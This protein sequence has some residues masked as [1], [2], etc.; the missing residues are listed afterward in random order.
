MW[1][2][3]RD[4]L[5][6]QHNFIIDSR[7][8]CAEVYDRDRNGLRDDELHPADAARRRVDHR[9]RAR[10]LD[11]RAVLLAGA[12]PQLADVEE[13]DDEARLAAQPAWYDDDDGLSPRDPTYALTSAGGHVYQAAICAP[14]AAVTA[15]MQSVGQ[16]RPAD[17]HVHW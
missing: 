13:D 6:A 12:N 7:S 1:C 15:T 14:R 11:P 5:C 2:L 4:A 9:G 16:T 10:A 3:T 8:E 17:R